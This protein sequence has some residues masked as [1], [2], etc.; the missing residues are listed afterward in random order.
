MKKEV[1]ETKLHRIAK[2]HNFLEIWQRSQNLHAIQK[3]SR[4]QN[5]QMTTVRYISDTEE[6]VKA[7]WSLFQHD[8]AA[9]F[10]L[11]ERLPLPPA[12]SAKNLPGGRTQIINVG[13]M[14]RI[15]SDAVENDEDKAPE[16]I[17]DT[18]DC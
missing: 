6:M 11:S 15:N 18:D 17:L 8:G 3:K 9:A 2:V 1:E 10:K 5:K 14:R 12:L 13:R 4:A 16:S 7:S